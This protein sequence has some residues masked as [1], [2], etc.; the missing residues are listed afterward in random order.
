MA[1]ASRFAVGVDF[2]L[3]HSQPAHRM[4]L[5][6][7]EKRQAA[8]TRDRMIFA[9]LPGARETRNGPGI[10]GCGK[11]YAGGW[12]PKPQIGFVRHQQ[13]HEAYPEDGSENHQYSVWFDIADSMTG[14]LCA[15]LKSFAKFE[16]NP[17]NI[18]PSPT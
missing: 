5:E 7:V 9:N 1:A 3:H 17:R 10:H 18:P 2:R 14:T 15:A 11:R 6:G 12:T 8:G 16:T 13:R 4:A